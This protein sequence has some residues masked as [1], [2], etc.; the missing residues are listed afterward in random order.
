[1]K[2]KKQSDGCNPSCHSAQVKDRN[3]IADACKGQ[4][5]KQRSK[6]TMVKNGAETSEVFVGAYAK[7]VL[8]SEA[9]EQ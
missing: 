5:I 2:K 1:M 8:R 3:K 4:Q 6:L 9:N 7:A